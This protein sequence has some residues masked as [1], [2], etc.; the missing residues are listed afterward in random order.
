VGVNVTVVKIS[1]AMKKGNYH[2]VAAEWAGV[3]LR[4]SNRCCARGKREDEG[5][6]FEF[7][8]AIREAEREA[9]INLVELIINAAAD[10]PK[11][12]EWWLTRKFP[13]RWGQDRDAIKQLLK[14]VRELRK[15]VGERPSANSDD[16]QP[17]S[18][19]DSPTP[20]R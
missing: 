10:D 11:H 17:N 20:A 15:I 7:W 8:Q 6:Y 2:E 1:A 18:G 9:E 4:T 3:P 19:S 13:E 12:A 5:E 14:E 16:G